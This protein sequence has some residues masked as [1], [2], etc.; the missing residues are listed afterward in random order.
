MTEF[1][2]PLDSAFILLEVA[3]SSMNIGAVV[4]LEPGDAGEKDRFELIR[5]TV[6][7]RIHEIPIFTKRVV[8][9]PFDM[10][11]PILVPD[12]GIDLERHVLRVAVPSPGTDGQFDGLVSDFFSRPL[13]PRRPLWQLLVVEGL[14]GGRSALAL[15]VHHALADGVS[16]A[17]AFAN[18]FD[19][20]PEIRAPAPAV[21]GPGD[22]T[23]TSS[24]GL[25]ALGLSRIRARPKLVLESVASWMT[26]LYGAVRAF[27]IV[28]LSHAAMRRGGDQPSIFEAKRTS[29]NAAPG[30][31]KEFHRLRVPLAEVKRA[32]KARGASVTDFVMAVSSGALRRLL[33]HR[34]ES[35]GRDLVAFVPINV[36][37]ETSAQ[38]GN[39]ISGK[40]I[41]LHTDITDSLRR[42]D[43]ISN[44]AATAT[45]RHRAGN[46]KVL[47][48]I[49]RVLG[50]M[51]LSFGAR[52]AS[53]SGVVNWIPPIANVMISSVPGPPIPLWLGGYRVV[54]AA[55][56]GPLIGNFS[57]NITVLGFGESLEFGLLGCARQMPDLV[58]LRDLL[59]EEANLLIDAP[60][61]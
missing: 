6:A 58:L 21:D 31:E 46:A 14:S 60:P 22:D 50:P 34:G 24:L 56:V 12:D 4:E 41:R 26:R 52:A 44:D 36:R 30:V 19:I 3:G 29:L 45:A 59:L 5:S 7:A 8:R 43:A 47:Q 49:P 38:L 37:D 57:L 51:A 40:L 32:S 15:K 35:L 33:E 20:S 27:V 13:N 10:T 61:A 42:L 2:D 28:T 11:W 23:V 1:L 39:Q 9:A 48:S 25:L 55:P 18:L 53:L 54:S 16:G 17:E